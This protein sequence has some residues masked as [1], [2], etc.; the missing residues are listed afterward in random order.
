MSAIDKKERMIALSAGAALL[1][2]LLGWLFLHHLENTFQEGSE[3]SAVL[4]A[5]R[6]IVAG[7]PLSP[8]LFSTVAVPK[9]YIQPA[10]MGDFSVLESSPGHPQFRNNVALMEGTQ[11][12][13]ILLSPLY[14]EEGLSQ[15]IPDGHVAVSF[16]VDNVRGLSGNIRPGDII[17]I[18]HSPK[19]PMPGLKGQPAAG[20]L[21]QAVPVVAIG[22]KLVLAERTDARE[23]EKSGKESADEN[24]D[25]LT[26]IT[27]SLN[28]LAAIRLTQSRESETLSVVLRPQG[29]DRVVEGLP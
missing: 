9:A 21:F 28:P 10:A 5:N 17:N 11:L 25:E 14:A 20:I 2:G 6:Y 8:E 27:V 23:T 16:G 18:L 12:T 15:V 22:K 26:V 19:V 13:Q 4:V 3:T 24:H 7:T 29:D 1:A